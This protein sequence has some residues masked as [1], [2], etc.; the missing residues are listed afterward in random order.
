MT[1]DLPSILVIDDQEPILDGMKKLLDVEGSRTS[2]ASISL[3]ALEAALG[4]DVPAVASFGLPTYDMHYARQ[5]LEGVRK[6]E[7]AIAQGKPFSVAFVDVHMPPGIDGVETSLA[8]WK[9]Q[10]DLEIVLCTAHSI[11]SWQEILA[12]VPRRDQLLILRKPFDAI[13]VR[14]L[15][16]CLTEK[17]RRG[18]ELSTR[19]AELEA[20]VEREVGRRL[21]VELA[22]H[23]KFEELGRLAAGIAHEISTP[24]QYIQS[25]LD[26]LGELVTEMTEAP[27][28]A[29]PLE[30]LRTAVND[31]TH[32]VGRITAIVRSVREYSH[33]TTEAEPIDLNHQIKMASEL[34]RS[35][36][37][38]DAELAL[39]LEE[40]PVICGYA[41]ELGRTIMNLLINAAHAIRAKGAGVGKI[42]VA[43]RA[44]K[45]SVTVSVSDTGTGIAPEHREKVFEPFF[46]TKPRG[47]GTGQ[48]LA[49]VRNTVEHHGG[50]IRLETTPGIGTTFILSFPT[51]T[52]GRRV[53]AA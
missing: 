7:R 32:G 23:Q 13:E 18:R 27:A 28:V 42:T 14:Q 46:T 38:Y 43:T 4:G 11:Y 52:S 24:A 16:A 1:N 3:D 49:L 21:E 33:S 5:G 29:A 19:M 34:A 31:A 45:E 26:F 25:S 20:R 47:E 9:L 30:D 35:Q 48:G 40:V 22:H 37:K 53:V 6:A 44:T 51:E 41:D 50:A 39:D 15:A 17:V 10:P 36:Y 8:L 2:D 12:K